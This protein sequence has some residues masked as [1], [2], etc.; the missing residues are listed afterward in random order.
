MFSYSF[1]IIA[2]WQIFFFWLPV[3]LIF[4]S[5][6]PPWG[7]DNEICI[8][9]YCNFVWTDLG[10]FIYLEVLIWFWSSGAWPKTFC[11][12][13]FPLC[14]LVVYGEL[15]PSSFLN[16]ISSPSQMSPSSLLSSLS[17]GLEI[18]KPLL[19]LNRGLTVMS[20]KKM[21]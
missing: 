15:I 6:K 8:V 11:T 14:I 1:L 7:V 20:T 5:E 2:Y 18:N 12:W 21:L 19:G 17:N 4:V 13:A 3:L 16:Q 9:L 10:W